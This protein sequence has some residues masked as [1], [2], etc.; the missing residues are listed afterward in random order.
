MPEYQPW[1][2]SSG[3][4][5]EPLPF[6]VRSFRLI[7][8][9]VKITLC[10]ILLFFSFCIGGIR[11]GRIWRDEGHSS[12][13]FLQYVFFFLGHGVYF[14]YGLDGLRVVGFGCDEGFSVDGQTNK[15]KIFPELRTCIWRGLRISKIAKKT[16]QAPIHVLCPFICITRRHTTKQPNAWDWRY[17]LNP[18]RL[19]INR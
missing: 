17:T 10:L 12:F 1:I 15:I 11:G 9:S 7:N 14:H 5:Y 8:C 6:Y 2:S 4:R 18:T 3:F 13:F 16:L 19:I